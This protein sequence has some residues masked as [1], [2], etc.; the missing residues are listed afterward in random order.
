MMS[1][2]EVVAGSGAVL[3]LHAGH[4]EHISDFGTASTSP[5]YMVAALMSSELHGWPNHAVWTAG[6]R[7]QAEYQGSPQ[8]AGSVSGVTAGCRERTRTRSG[9][10]AYVPP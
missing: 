2:A 8:G 4:P 3:R 6:P 1:T 7:R 9:T 5:Y 10:R